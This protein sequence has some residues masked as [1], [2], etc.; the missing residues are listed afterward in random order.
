MAA[1][2]QPL[3]RVENGTTYF[4][5]DVVDQTLY[6]GFTTNHERNAFLL[7][8]DKIITKSPQDL[9]PGG[10]AVTGQRVTELWMRRK[11]HWLGKRSNVNPQ[12]H[13]VLP[14][15]VPPAGP[16]APVPAAD[17]VDEEG[18]D[19]EVE[20]EPTAESG[21][22]AELEPEAPDHQ[23]APHLA[24]PQDPL[25][26][27]PN[28]DSE[29][30]SDLAEMS[31]PYVLRDK[32]HPPWYHHPTK[33]Q[34][35]FIQQ[36]LGEEK[37][38]FHK[39]L[40]QRLDFLKDPTGQQED[41]TVTFPKKA[42]WLF[43]RV[44]D[45]GRVED[46]IAVK[47]ATENT[48]EI[49]E[50]EEQPEQEELEYESR[51]KREVRMNLALKPLRCRHILQHRGSARRTTQKR[52][53]TGTGD[54]LLGCTAVYVYSQVAS[55][56]LQQLMDRHKEAERPIPEHFI[57]YTMS[58]IVDALLAFKYGECESPLADEHTEATYSDIDIDI[59]IEDPAPPTNTFTAINKKP[60]K[61]SK[62]IIH[63]D[64]KDSNIF[65]AGEDSKYPAYER[66]LLSD[67]DLTLYRDDMINEE[68]A[69]FGQTLGWEPP[70]KHDKFCK[71]I[72]DYEP[73]RWEVSE[74][75]D[76]WSLGV[77]A[78]QMMHV[79]PDNRHASQTPHDFITKIH[80]VSQ[81]QWKNLGKDGV[82]DPSEND[83]NEAPLEH[84]RNENIMRNYK[85]LPRDY[86]MR[87]FQVIRKCLQLNPDRR[88]GLEHLRR[89]IRRQMQML[90]GRYP[91]YTKRKRE[92]LP[93]Y[94]RVE[95]VP[96]EEQIK[97]GDK[98]QRPTKRRRI[99]P[100]D[101][102]IR[103][104]YET[105]VNAWNNRDKNL[106]AQARAIHK[107]HQLRNIDDD[108]PPV[109]NATTGWENLISSLRKRVDSTSAVWQNRG[110]LPREAFEDENKRA[111]LNQLLQINSDY[112]PLEDGED[113]DFRDSWNVLQHAGHW[114]L[115]LLR[116]GYE[117]QPRLRH[118]SDIHRGIRDYVLIRPSTV[119]GKG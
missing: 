84:P 76:I 61:K 116:F 95:F 91:E 65:F 86:S 98:Y 24:L 103:K 93:E 13:A 47:Y 31:P 39:V 3:P 58:S 88:I 15:P 79:H 77:L 78:L 9:T 64:I 81:K 49:E 80:K 28:L 85:R 111:M 20:P 41:H 54:K 72:P 107:L 37:W 74:K 21:P 26:Q 36:N 59:Q 16:V 30:S 89:K 38:Q 45:T 71:E 52:L 35:G 108:D 48:E 106:K 97:R 57:W 94:S 63:G 119:F 117:P 100:P 7:M 75:A 70:E 11:S 118:K 43:V 4:C 114:G 60:N 29:P 22:A 1:P 33:G 19:P 25:I 5:V 104:D 109:P 82:E 23:V 102:Q 62:P 67:F 14:A 50:D 42:N 83:I 112:G 101:E 27:A 2:A 10:A 92:T 8:M 66:P 44:G 87:L 55:L 53:I 69:R 18:P 110:K 96:Q 17:V 6:D 68:N 73:R 56:D 115:L 34:R 99:E 32:V 105:T 113:D 51:A 90:D 40:Y 46:K 12:V